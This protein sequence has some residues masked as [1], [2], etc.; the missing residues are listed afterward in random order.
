[1]WKF[2][3]ECS[4]RSKG[5]D[6][7]AIPRLGKLLVLYAGENLIIRQLVLL[8]VVTCCELMKAV[9]LTVKNSGKVF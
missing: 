2:N 7:C 8:S 9:N 3:E 6:T 4:L 1:M 5:T